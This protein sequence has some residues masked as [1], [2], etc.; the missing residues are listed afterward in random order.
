MISVL[1]GFLILLLVCFIA[2]AVNDMQ[3][4]SAQD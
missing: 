2:S 4:G 1:S 3:A